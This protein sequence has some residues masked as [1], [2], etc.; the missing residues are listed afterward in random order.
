MHRMHRNIKPENILLNSNGEVCV[1][2]GGGWGGGGEGDGGGFVKNRR[3]FFA[4][5]HVTRLYVPRD[6]FICVTWIIDMCDLTPLYVR[7]DSFICVTWLIRTYISH[8]YVW[9]DSFICVTWLI[10]T[11]DVTPSYLWHDSCVYVIWLILRA[12]RLIFMS[13]LF[14][15]FFVSPHPWHESFLCATWCGFIHTLT[16]WHIPIRDMTYSSAKP[17][18]FSCMTWHIPLWLNPNPMFDMNHFYA[19]HDAVLYMS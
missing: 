5:C 15:S 14:L 12:T 10:H 17:D 6:L 11:C 13:F 19:Q 4:I 9:S 7:H 3:F 1:W 2:G 18:I 16:I 8:S